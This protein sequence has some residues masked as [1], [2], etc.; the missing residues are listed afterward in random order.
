[1]F[2]GEAA[3][4]RQAHHSRK[5]GQRMF[6][7]RHPAASTY[8]FPTAASSSMPHVLKSRQSS[9]D[10]HLVT[11]SQ[12]PSR[13]QCAATPSCSR[14]EGGCFAA[15]SSVKLRKN[16]TESGSAST[17]PSRISRGRFWTSS[18]C[19]TKRRRS[20]SN[21]RLTR[22]ASSPPAKEVSKDQGKPL[23]HGRM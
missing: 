17:S 10:R 2:F 8:Q 11:A 7:R 13:R 12:P 15:A 23:E 4:P 14:T 22:S 9:V 18:S 19:T 21:E 3:A 20:F 5:S 6:S 1:M 16:A